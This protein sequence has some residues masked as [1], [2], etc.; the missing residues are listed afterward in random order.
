MFHYVLYS[1][2]RTC[3]LVRDLWEVNYTYRTKCTDILNVVLI[4]DD[5]RSSQV[6]ALY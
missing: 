5:I 2:R 3:F 6:L 1:Y 4:C